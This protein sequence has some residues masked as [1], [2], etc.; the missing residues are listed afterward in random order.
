MG[1]TAVGNGLSV[2]P[3]GPDLDD[4]N[5]SITHT[6][7]PAAKHTTTTTAAITQRNLLWCG[8]GC[9]RPAR[10]GKFVT[11]WTGAG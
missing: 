11:P 3:G 8:D 7:A 1:T 10:S 4:P 5:G 2:T 9:G 6:A